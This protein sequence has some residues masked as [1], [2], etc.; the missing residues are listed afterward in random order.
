MN[1]PQMELELPPSKQELNELLG[2][3]IPQIGDGTYTLRATNGETFL[4]LVRGEI[5]DVYRQTN[6]AIPRDKARI[7]WRDL[8]DYGEPVNF[9]TS[10]T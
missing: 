10:E 9:V 5:V 2:F 3:E 8:R 6:E 1:E 4:F 7:L